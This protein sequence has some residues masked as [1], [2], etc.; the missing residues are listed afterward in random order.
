MGHFGD[1]AV[2]KGSLEIIELAVKCGIGLFY[3]SQC[4]KTYIKR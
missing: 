4:N 3:S 2:Y 1:D